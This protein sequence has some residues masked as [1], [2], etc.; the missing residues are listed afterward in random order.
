M[1]VPADVDR[2]QR[3]V[4]KQNQKRVIVA[5]ERQEEE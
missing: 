1:P 4:K 5:W 2:A 3:K